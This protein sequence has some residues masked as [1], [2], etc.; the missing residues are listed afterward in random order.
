MTLSKGA[1]LCYEWLRSKTGG[2]IVERQE[3]LEA[4]DWMD[5]S[6]KTYLGKN[7]LSPFLL[8]LEND[9]LKVLMP[10]EEVSED[11]FHEV[12]TQTAPRKITLSPGL[13]ISGN[14][15]TYTLLEPIGKGAVGHVWSA[16]D[17]S[18]GEVTLVAVKVML[19]RVDLLAESKLVN[20]RERFRREARNGATLDHPNIV[21]YLDTG[22]IYSN[23]LLVME[24]GESSI[25]HRLRGD[26]PLS[27]DESVNVVRSVLN[28]LQYLHEKNSP[29]RDIKPDNILIFEDRCKVADLGI[30]KWSDFEPG[31]TTGGTIT[32]SSVQL[33]SWFYMAPEQQED[34]HEAIPASDI[35]ALGVTWIEMLTGTL[36]SPQAVGAM[37]YAQPTE[38]AKISDLIGQMIKYDPE[39]RP[40]VLKIQ[41]ILG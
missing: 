16:Q 20:V 34:P 29:H 11:F 9:R 27:L 2:E 32:R 7:K 38:D 21:R 30:V 36:P 22:E 41:T 4:T 28:A 19:P 40:S 39:N 26:E 18:A 6:L 24:L 17:L 10:G 3:V 37:A 23:P 5:T 25:G 14:K 12:F 35:Y 33:G 15:A 13:K 31:F 1:R 8:P